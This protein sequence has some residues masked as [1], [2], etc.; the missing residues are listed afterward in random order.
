MSAEKHILTFLWFVGHRGQ[1]LVELSD[2]FNITQDSVR[3]IIK[4]VNKFLDDIS[5]T[6][7]CWPQ[8]KN[9]IKN[10]FL[11]KTG[12]PNVLGTLI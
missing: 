10:G 7:V 12:F 9:A 3:T 4:R 5:K 6:I 1:T 2:R 11:A 8:N